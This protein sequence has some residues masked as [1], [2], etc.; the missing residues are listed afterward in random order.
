MST[1]RI[2]A[3]RLAAL[4]WPVV[5]VYESNGRGGIGAAGWNAPVAIAVRDEAAAHELLRMLS[6]TLLS[7]GYARARIHHGPAQATEWLVAEEAVSPRGAP[8]R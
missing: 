7:G 5:E 4:G 1:H 8:S 2:P 3:E 6:L